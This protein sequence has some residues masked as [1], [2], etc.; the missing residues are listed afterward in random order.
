[1]QFKLIPLLIFISSVLA[2][3]CKKNKKTDNTPPPPITPSSSYNPPP[4]NSDFYMINHENQGLCWTKD[5]LTFKKYSSKIGESS[6]HGYI[7][8]T[9]LL[10]VNN[11][12]YFGNIFDPENHKTIDCSKT[13]NTVSWINGVITCFADEHPNKYLGSCDYKNGETQVTFTLLSSSDYYY[14]FTNLGHAVVCATISGDLAYTRDGKN[15]QLK[16]ATGISFDT[17]FRKSGST[18]YKYSSNGNYSH[19]TDTSF[20]TGSWTNIQSFSSTNNTSDS[21]GYFQHTNARIS[22]PQITIFGYI[23]TPANNYVPAINVSNDNGNTFATTLL[24]GIP[25][26]KFTGPVYAKTSN[27]TLVILYDNVSFKYVPYVSTD[28]LNFTGHPPGNNSSYADFLEKFY[29]WY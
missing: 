22:P 12:I 15:W 20:A 13:V 7:K 2:V 19:T 4:T 17:R 9:I 25:V 14:T 24:N 10:Q 11:K 18:F 21:A 27:H 5:F 8:D 16:S 3:S 1:M 6:C 26:Q 23:Y 28:N 29:Y